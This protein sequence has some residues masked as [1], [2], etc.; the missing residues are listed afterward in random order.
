MHFLYLGVDPSIG[1]ACVSEGD[2]TRQF[3]DTISTRTDEGATAVSI[4]GGVASA[5]GADHVLGDVVGEDCLAVG[6]RVQR[7]LDPL[8]MVWQQKTYQQ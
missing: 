6:C 3:A 5:A 2:D 7:D 8:Q 1:T 4:A